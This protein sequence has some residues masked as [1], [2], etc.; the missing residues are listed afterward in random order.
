[1]KMLCDNHG[2]PSAM[3]LAALGTVISGCVMLVSA[4]F[5]AADPGMANDALW[6]VGIGLTGKSAQKLFEQPSNSE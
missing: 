4:A 3:R 1:M 6:L 5:G 2:K